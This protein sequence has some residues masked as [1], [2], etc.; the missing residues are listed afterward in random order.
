MKRVNK[1]HLL[2]L[3]VLKALVRNGFDFDVVAK[4]E[5][6]ALEELRNDESWNMTSPELI[7]FDAWF[8]SKVQK[9]TYRYNL[10]SVE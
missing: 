7:R 2:I 6:E 9:V 1:R 3:Q 4:K 10:V 8:Q 5:Q